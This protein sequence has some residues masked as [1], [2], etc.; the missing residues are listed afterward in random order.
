MA[1]WRKVMSGGGEAERRR[2]PGQ[3]HTDVSVHVPS[4]QGRGPMS[5][6][7]GRV[8]SSWLSHLPKAQPMSPG[9]L[10]QTLSVQTLTLA[11]LHWILLNL[12]VFT[13]QLHS[14]TL[15]LWQV[16]SSL[17]FYSEVYMSNKHIKITWL[18]SCNLWGINIFFSLQIW[19]LWVLWNNWCKIIDLN[20]MCSKLISQDAWLPA[21]KLLCIYFILSCMSHTFLPLYTPPN[22]LNY[23]CHLC[24]LYYYIPKDFLLLLPDDHLDCLVSFL[25]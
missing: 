16:T 23:L 9:G 3:R 11:D 5:P 24:R 7:R 12:I 8:P 19:L 10:G 20:Y 2:N 1:G 21:G 25:K 22:S 14:A 4:L 15:T 17:T 18:M 13:C 6:Q